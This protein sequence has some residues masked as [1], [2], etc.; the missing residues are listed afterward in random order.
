M[1]KMCRYLFISMLA[2][3]S[4]W[5]NAALEIV[6]TEGVDS[7]RPIAVVP[8]AYEGTGEMPMRISEVVAADLRR[9]GKFKPIAS[10]NMPQRP[11]TDA[12]VDY[13]AWVQEGVEAIVVGR[14]QQQN[15]G[16][17]LVSYE[18]IDVLR[19][20]ITGGE[21]RI[22]NNGKLIKSQDHVLDA[23]ETVITAQNF[24]RYGHRI[25]DVVYE[26]LTGERGAFL[27][28]IAYVIVRDQDDK[29]YQLVVADYDG[30]NEQV[31]LRSK[32]PLMSPSW[33][34]DGNKLAYVTFENRQ[35]QIYIQDIYTG[36]RQLVTS[37]PGINGAPQ[38]S[39][40]GT[41][42]AMVLSKDRTGA[43]ELYLYDL[44]TKQERRLTRHRS[45]DTE[46]TWHP[47]GKELLFT[48]ERGGNAQ[49]YKLNLDSGR[50]K[51]MTFDGDM[52][53]NGSVTPDGKHLVMVNR[54]LGRYHIAK[55]DL[56]SG[57]FQ[58]LTRTRLDESPSVAPNGSM[59]IYSTMHNNKNV[60]ALVSMDGRFK[61]RLPVLDG[62][63][64]APAWSPFL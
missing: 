33:S 58:V 61:A 53:L 14:V 2:S 22:L 4:L 24:R 64:K 42:L 57:N 25:S 26:A 12:D 6:I 28:K 62:Q 27:T 3:V 47:N 46:P 13:S 50:V 56:E 10:I 48:S 15:G 35:S 41:K 63:V 44:Q 21:T 49:I 43:T 37:H 45:I 11:S 31:L 19:G 59:I 29:P 40:D 7:A 1:V 51:R 16:R 30:Y 8:F 36:Q 9:S 5:A 60:L 38:F 52:N 20:Q 34:P 39:P 32:E 18:L 54:T 23:R 55:K 17:Y